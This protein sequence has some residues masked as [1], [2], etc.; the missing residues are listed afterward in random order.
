MPTLLR[1]PL[2]DSLA[3]QPVTLRHTL[4]IL[5]AAACALAVPLQLR[6][7]EHMDADV[8]SDLYSPWVGVRALLHHVDPYSPAVTAQIQTGIYGHVLSPADQH[9]PEAF[10]YPPWV[11]LPLAPFT[12][13]SWHTVELLFVIVTP[14]VILAT[15][16]VW[17]RLFRSGLDRTRVIAILVIVLAS[18]PAVW[19]C[20]QRQP[21]VYVIA[22]IA[23]ST[24]L[25]RRGSDI[26][27]GIL[28][29]LATVKPQ[30]VLLVAAWSLFVA[31][32]HRRWR[33]IAAFSVSL[34]ALVA[35]SALLFPYSISHWIH[36]AIAYTHTAGKI[37][38]FAWLLGPRFGLLAGLALLAALGW[39]LGRF[40]LAPPP[41][42]P[43]FVQAVALVLAA[44]ACLIP[45]NAWLV[46]DNL[47]L[48]PGFLLLARL[49]SSSPL[50]T[51]LRALAAIA[52]LLALLVTPVC[53]AIGAR[54]G[55]RVDLVMPPFLVNY[56]LPLPCMAALLFAPFHPASTP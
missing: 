25:F 11:A 20:Y 17:M 40:R 49:A 54:A 50:T 51:F 8:Y 37:S 16:W 26:A 38:L 15:A 2:L 1:N 46:F 55:F 24:L 21:S 19:G 34:A 56:L 14:C 18:W 9:D 33:F 52:L 31:L 4:L 5:L 48:L 29:A 10:V 43:L 42:D 27:A 12:F 23:L 39:R 30:L 35:A 47:L 45:T 7:V 3:D 32:R 22:A 53:A 6:M 36:A 44:T 28:L 13:L 41:H